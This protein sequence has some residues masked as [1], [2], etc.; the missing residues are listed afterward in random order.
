MKLSQKATTRPKRL[1]D[2][3]MRR[4]LLSL[5]KEAENSPTNLTVLA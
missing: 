2:K 5:K 3:E 1:T 4:I